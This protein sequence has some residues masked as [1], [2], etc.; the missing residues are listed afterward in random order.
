MSPEKF[1]RGRIYT[2]TQQELLDHTAR[3]RK[4]IPTEKLLE[5]EVGEG[6]E[7][8]VDFLGVYVD[9][10]SKA[11]FKSNYREQTHPYSALPTRERH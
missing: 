1:H 9:T 2:H 5:Y 4:I 8:L 10:T 6:W 3:V 7:R 11:L